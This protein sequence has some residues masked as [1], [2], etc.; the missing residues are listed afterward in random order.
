MK[1]GVMEEI[2]RAKF[3]QNPDLRQ[4]LVD[5]G[6]LELM[7]GNYWHDTFWGVDCK[8]G[9]GKNHL[10]I[11]L[12]QIRT[13]LGGAEY[14][15]RVRQLRDEKEEIRRTEAAALQATMDSVRAELEAL[16]A[17][18]FT[19][20]E[21]DTRTFGRVRILQQEGN[22]LRFEVNG[23][24]KTFSLPGCIVN[25]FLI[26]EDAGVVDAF[27]RRQALEERLKSLEKDGLTKKE[28]Q[29]ADSAEE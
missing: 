8:S 27:R 1:L 18:D 11:I 2:I 26:P 10:G 28:A 29:H 21:M 6:D 5:T 19:G 20:M 13:E 12:M 25:G 16:P 7:E 14:A 23:A 9:K 3:V 4:K 24:V 15:A 17:Y 22:R